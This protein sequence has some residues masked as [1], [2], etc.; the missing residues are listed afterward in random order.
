MELDTLLVLILMIP[1]K[2]LHRIPCACLDILQAGSLQFVHSFL[3][4]VL[5][6]FD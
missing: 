3:F 2:R 5:V 1:Q 6:V 4:V